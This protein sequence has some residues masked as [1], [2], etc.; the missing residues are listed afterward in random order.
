MSIWVIFGRPYI[1]N[2][3]GRYLDELSQQSIKHA[4]KNNK[5]TKHL[6]ESILKFR[7]EQM[8]K[9]IDFLRNQ[10][11][12]LNEPFAEESEFEAMIKDIM[13]YKSEAV[14]EE[15]NDANIKEFFLANLENPNLNDL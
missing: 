2:F 7:M 10:M 11:I 3:G 6:V 1:D 8:L 14:E 12:L 4:Q 15:K 9:H 13:A 5:W